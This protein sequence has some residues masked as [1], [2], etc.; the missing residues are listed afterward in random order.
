MKPKAE[1]AAP[2][3]VQGSLFTETVVNSGVTDPVLQTTS[4]SLVPVAEGVFPDKP[5]DSYTVPE[6][7]ELADVV[8]RAVAADRNHR[9]Q[10][11]KHS[12]RERGGDYSSL[13]AGDVLPGFGI[14]THRNLSEAQAHARTLQ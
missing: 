12:A 13:R 14:V 1:P 3:E 8:Q 9:A 2:S 10:L 6:G 7:G 11:G 5:V 4:V